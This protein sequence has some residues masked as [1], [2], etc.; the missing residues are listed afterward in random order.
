MFH[1]LAGTEIFYKLRRKTLAE[2]KAVAAQVAS[3]EVEWERPMDQ[4]IFSE[5]FRESTD[6]I[7]QIAG[8]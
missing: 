7:R 5:Q 3:L 2:A 6:A 1:A 8:D 4:K